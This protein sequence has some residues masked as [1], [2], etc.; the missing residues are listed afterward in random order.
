MTESGHIESRRVAVLAY[1]GMTAF[2][3]GIAAEIFGLS[4]LSDL[5]WPGVDQ[6]WYDLRLCTETREK[7]RVVG[8]ATLR[9]PHGLGELVDAHTVII[10]SVAD[11]RAPVS[12][13][14]VDAVREAADRGARVVSFCSGAFVLA[15]AGLL[16]GKRATT[17]WR[18]TAM[19]QEQ[20]PAIDVDPAPLYVD[21]GTVLTSAGCSAGL[22]LSL[23]LVR[24][25]Y[26]PQ[27]AN[28]VARSLVA[29]PHRSG[30]QAQY[31]E[32]PMPALD[33]DT[34]ITDS[35][36]WALAHIDVP[37]SL[38]ELADR[39][40]LSRRSYLRQFTKA[41][42]TTPIKWLIARRI[43]TSLEL[44]ETSDLPVERIA[45]MVGFGSVV[46]FRHHFTRIMSTSPSEYRSTFTAA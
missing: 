23:H 37:I 28:D 16:D 17:H 42:G 18:Y 44:L 40:S 14:L 8:G 22:D 45:G 11:V 34:T 26:G 39:A 2:E 38:D 9:T 24:H 1:D 30:G 20:Y 32:S 35:M 21:E 5:F 33:V 27:I 25:D 7:V 31:I 19:L 4:E 6:P 3:M 41:T 43:D 36:N 12:P 13:R 10:P 15:A 29:A 46:T